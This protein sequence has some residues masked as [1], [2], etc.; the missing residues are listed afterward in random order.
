MGV[1]QMLFAAS[2]FVS[3]TNTYTT[4]TSATET[5][6][7]GAQTVVIEEWG[8]GASGGSGDAD[9]SGS[10]GG[11]GGY[12]RTS[13]NVT[14]QGGKTFTYSV[15]AAGTSVIPNNPGVDGGASSV[16]GGT[17]TGFT[18]MT[19]NGGTHGVIFV[20]GPG[21][22]GGVG[23]TASGGTIVNTTGGTGGIGLGTSPNNG[24]A[25]GTPVTGLNSATAGDGGAGGNIIGG[26][27]QNS[28]SGVAGK[29]VFSYA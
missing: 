7:S 11:A 20:P 18:T 28:V 10:G 24:G 19:A 8:G 25:G 16:A 21:A 14:T 1:Q 6:P 26:V 13:F 3:V 5:V 15:G 23:G 4:G 12:S 2:A 29:I 22:S 17:V 27:G 9:G